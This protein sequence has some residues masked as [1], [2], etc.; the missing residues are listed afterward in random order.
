MS[1]PEHPPPLQPL[2]MEPP[3]GDAVS[4]TLAPSGKADEQAGPQLMPAGLLV[5]MPL[6]APVLLT[7]RAYEVPSVKLAETDVAPVT[8]T[9]QVSVPEQP[10]PLQ[11]EKIEPPVGEAVSVT[12]VPLRKAD[13]QTAPHRMPGG[14][15]VTLPL[16]APVLLIERAKESPS[17]KSA[18]TDTAPVTVTVHVSVPEHPPPLQPAKVE[19]AEGE[20]VSVT[21]VLLG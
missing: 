1:V 13:E 18:E 8:V 7:E 11:P 10:P 20:A 3:E 21:F 17:A 19:P 5:T 16:P 15:L 4:V 12:L 14:P 9:V 2:K 6:P